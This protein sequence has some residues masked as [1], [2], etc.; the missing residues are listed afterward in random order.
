MA[1]HSALFMGRCVAKDGDTFDGKLIT[2]VLPNSLAVS[3]RHGLTAWEAE[4][5]YPAEQGGHGT[6]HRGAFSENQFV[7][8]LDPSKA[9][10]VGI[11]SSID[12][13]FRWN[14]EEEILAL[15][16]G[17]VLVPSPL[18]YTY[19]TAPPPNNAQASDAKV[20]PAQAPAPAAKPNCSAAARAESER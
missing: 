10:E 12:P 18:H 19:A 14:E 5:N 2:R 20:P 4:W 11:A 17:I 9:S 15:K 7:T 1:I 3:N 13:D 16:P 6:P 8:E